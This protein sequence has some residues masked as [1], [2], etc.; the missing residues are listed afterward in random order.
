MDN[1]E[2]EEITYGRELVLLC[3]KNGYRKETA[4]N[5]VVLSGSVDD[6]VGAL[7]EFISYVKKKMPA[8]ELMS[9]AMKYVTG[10]D[11]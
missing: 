3:K 5:L 7:K 1:I 2:D 11:W 6:M 4:E 9:A 8:P 10:E